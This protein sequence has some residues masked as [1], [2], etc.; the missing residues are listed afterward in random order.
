M[1]ALPE[2]FSSDRDTA[3]KFI[4][5]LKNY[6]QLNHAVTQ[7]Q[8]NKTKIALALTCIQGP[9]VTQW[10]RIVGDW[11]DNLTPQEDAD[12][13]VWAQFLEQ[14]NAQYQDSTKEQKA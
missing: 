14:F 1:G 5:A 2:I 8:S 10:V 4:E 12:P 6:F 7:L 11:V 13:D 3:D 9:L